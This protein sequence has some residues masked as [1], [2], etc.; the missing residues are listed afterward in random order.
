MQESDLP[1]LD[2]E[3][4]NRDHRDQVETINVVIAAIE[5]HDGSEATLGALDE[6]IDDFAE[7]TREH[8]N[9][10][11]DQ[12]HRYGFPAFVLHKEEHA[13]TLH[14]MQERIE[15]WRAERDLDLLG[16]YF[17]EQFPAWLVNH[18]TLMDSVC[19]QFVAG[20]AH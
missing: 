9:Q 13:R 6:A 12:M 11:D 7:H 4:M 18:V 8:F 10:E 16:E 20:K 5:A 17:R 14:R 1:T 19:A 3:S 2:M 15:R